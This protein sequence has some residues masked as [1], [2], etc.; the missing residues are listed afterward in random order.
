MFED[1]EASEEFYD[2]IAAD[3]SS[4]DDDDDDEEDGD[5]ELDRK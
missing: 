1:V 4:S 3:S 5:A 2:A